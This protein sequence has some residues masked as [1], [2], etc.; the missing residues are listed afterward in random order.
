M[1]NGCADGLRQRARGEEM[2]AMWKNSVEKEKGE[3]GGG[4]ER[5]AA[6]AK[7][8][9]KDYFPNLADSPQK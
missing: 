6:P 2:L 5:A 9:P 7:E 3:G 1:S 4:G 8:E